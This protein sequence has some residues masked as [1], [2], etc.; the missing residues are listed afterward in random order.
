[1]DC[2]KIISKISAEDKVKT[3]VKALYDKQ[4]DDIM[5]LDLRGLTVIADYFVICSAQSSTKTAALADGVGEKLSA[6]GV[7]PMNVE[8]MAN[9][10][11]VLMDYNDVIVHVFLE[12]QRQYYKLERLWLDAPR[13]AVKFDASGVDINPGT[14]QAGVNPNALPEDVNPGIAVVEGQAGF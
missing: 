14:L 7:K 12:E 11:W 6:L 3:I 13:V 5:V 4:G 9:A 10:S 1:M 2:K 8:G